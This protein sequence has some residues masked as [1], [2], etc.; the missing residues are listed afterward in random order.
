VSG[1]AYPDVS[2]QS[3][4]F[5]VVLG[6]RTT[7]EAGTSASCPT[8][9][10]IISLLNDYRLSIGKSSLG[11]LNPLIYGNLPT[12]FNDITSGQNPGCGTNGFK[13]LAGW[14]PVTGFGTPDF[15]KLQALVK[16]L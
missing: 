3:D 4:Y 16:N 2:A 8:V 10:S 5:Q 15:G 11:F 1:R 13:A 9:A 7:G 14:D 6:G 12:G